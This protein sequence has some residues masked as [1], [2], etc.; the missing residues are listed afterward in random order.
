MRIDIVGLD[1]SGLRDTV[2]HFNVQ[3]ADGEDP[4][5]NAGELPYARKKGDPEASH[6]NLAPLDQPPF[7]AFELQPGAIG[8]KG[9]LVTSV[10]AEVLDGDDRPIPGLS[11]SSNNAAHIMASSTPVMAEPSDRN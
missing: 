5:H 7:Y 2:E 1:P 10:D 11:A 3:A 9:C 6:P 4:V 8:T